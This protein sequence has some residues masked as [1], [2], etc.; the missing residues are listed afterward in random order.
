MFTVR[1]E[2]VRQLSQTTRDFAFIRLDGQAVEIL[3]ADEGLEA[4]AVHEADL[5]MAAL[6][7][8]VGLAPPLAAIRAGRGPM[9]SRRW[10][11]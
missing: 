1:L 2:R 10:L 9:T 4:V 8:A 6:V 5:V 3:V 11:K 7:G